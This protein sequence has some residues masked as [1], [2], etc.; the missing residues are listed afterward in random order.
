MRVALAAVIWLLSFVALI[1]C[2]DA[3]LA[4]IERNGRDH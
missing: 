2:R 4:V 3:A 1:A